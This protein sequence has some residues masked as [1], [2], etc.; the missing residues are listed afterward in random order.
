MNE[1]ETT[2]R[3]TLGEILAARK[4]RKGR[5]AGIDSLGAWWHATEPGVVT[6]RA[7]G[8]D[9][10]GQSEPDMHATIGARHYRDGHIAVGVRVTRWHQDTGERVTWRP[11][12]ALWD[13]KTAEDVIHAIV[14]SD[15]G[16]YYRPRW[17]DEVV[18]WCVSLGMPE[19][20][21]APDEGVAQ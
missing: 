17:R 19:A 12:A 10:V 1:N 8:G 4:A 5:A 7:W 6:T 16:E 11:I 2:P 9:G 14:S 20:A 13:S 3:R 21:P 15:G 18:A